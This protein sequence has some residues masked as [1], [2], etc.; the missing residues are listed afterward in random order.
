MGPPNTHVPPIPTAP[1]RGDS[2]RSCTA[3][4]RHGSGSSA[5]LLP[6]GSFPA[7]P[8]DCS[9]PVGIEGRPPR[10]PRGY[11]CCEAMAA[12]PPEELINSPARCL[13]RPRAS[14][15]SPDGRVVD[16][17]EASMGL[18]GGG[19]LLPLAGGKEP[20]GF[21]PTSRAPWHGW[22]WPP[23]VD[24]HPYGDMPEPPSAGERMSPGDCPMP[25]ITRHIMV[26]TPFPP[27]RCPHHHA[28]PRRCHPASQPQE[29]SAGCCCHPP[30]LSA[31]PPKG[32]T[33]ARSGGV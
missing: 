32:Q 28:R 5:L 22:H 10:G 31:C 30:V 20:G 7:A 6:P 9:S 14:A 13:P 23:P 24:P 8:A 26:T 21:K 16:S 11:G 19:G 18:E 12:W 29:T 1:Q 33:P 25:Q 27:R 3:P 15:E 2:A 4:S 17:A